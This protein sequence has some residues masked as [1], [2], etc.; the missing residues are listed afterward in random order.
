MKIIMSHDVDHLYPRDHFFK[1]LY[2]P[3]LFVRTV[4]DF[5]RGKCPFSMILN[6]VK[7]IFAKRMH[8]IFEVVSLDLMY[9]VQSTFFWGVASGLGMSYSRNDV[10]PLIKYVKQNGL[11]IGVHGIT[12]DDY[13]K[14]LDECLTFYHITGEYPKGIR[15]HYVRYNEDTFLF[16]NKIGY[17]YDSSRF[18]KKTMGSVEKPYKVGD[19]W[20]FPLAIMDVYL[21]ENL[22]KA[23]LFTLSRIQE[24]ENNGI[25]YMTVL[26]HDNYFSAQSAF[27]KEWYMW[28]VEYV[29]ESEK[30]TFVSFEQAIGEMKG[31]E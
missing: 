29:A 5:F 17:M 8:N 24:Y 10:S 14:M 16:E 3:K 13:D 22:E 11:G 28:F 4:I 6:S 9:N 20:E 26:F 23:K 25:A 1:D 12:F 2:F 18:C 15:M 21:P 7:L 27:L 19:M 31:N 30:H